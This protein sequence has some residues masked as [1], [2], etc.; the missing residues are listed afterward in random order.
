M[1]EHYDRGWWPKCTGV[2]HLGRFWEKEQTKVVVEVFILDSLY[3]G[4]TGRP[5]PGYPLE[6]RRDAHNIG[7]MSYALQVFVSSTCYDL[8]DLRAAVRNWLEQFR[9]TPLM[10]DER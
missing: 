2:C 3:A 8:R 1:G 7:I 10:S 9:L 4:C 6:Q 5:V